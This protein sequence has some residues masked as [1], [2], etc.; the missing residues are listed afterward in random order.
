MLLA[1]GT[2]VGRVEP[3]ERVV[4]P[5][6]DAPFLAL[7][8]DGRALLEVVHGL[9]GPLSGRPAVQ[10]DKRLWHVE[11]AQELVHRPEAHDVD[12]SVLLAGARL[13][14]TLAVLLQAFK[15]PEH[16]FEERVLLS[17]SLSLS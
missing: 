17:C 15:G 5:D 7:E 2:L 13:R 3:L 11:P 16:L 12:E 6:V 10:A 4:Q 8:G 1:L 14:E 9:V